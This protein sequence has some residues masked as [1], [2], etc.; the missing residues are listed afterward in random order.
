MIVVII[1]GGSGTR[2]WPLSVP[3]YPKHLLKVGDD[4]KTILQNS[5]NRAT[6][7]GKTY[8]ITEQSHSLE[9]QK[10][11]VGLNKE[12]IIVEPARKGTA[13]CIIAAL[14]KIELVE[15]NEPIAFIHA[16]HYIRDEESFSYSFHQ[17]E[18]VALNSEGIVLMGIEPSYPAT[19]FGYIK[20][21][22]RVKGVPMTYTVNSFKEKPDLKLAKSY[23]RSGQYL[24]NCGYFIAT[25]AA[26]ETSMKK[27][28]PNL[29]KSYN[30]LKSS[31]DR[32]DKVY[33]N[34]Q[35]EAIDYALIEKT[36]NLKVV[37]ASFDWLDI[38]SFA[39]LYSVVDK[40]EQGNYI[41]GRVS[42]NSVTNCFIENT[43]DKPLAI[44]GLDNCIVVSTDSGTLVARKDMSQAVGDIAKTLI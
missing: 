12:Q 31:N 23:L 4:S 43:S 39:D 18:Q 9:V 16:D 1:A 15:P 26:F 2:L 41:K 38:G 21:Q 27:Y 30:R 42:L 10:Q 24:W 40:D 35:A 11:L 8:V 25:K 3:D 6:K 20:K 44:L 36:P 19:G 7:L 5:Y 22:D 29:F 14:A 33:G 28:A 34:L 13:N 37:Q 32:F 17:A